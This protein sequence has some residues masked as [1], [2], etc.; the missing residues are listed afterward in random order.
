MAASYPEITSVGEYIRLR[1]SEDPAEYSRSAWA[2]MPLPVW[3]DLARNHP[4]M[5][6]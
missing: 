6:F 4:D 3:W 5:R 2:A 1:E